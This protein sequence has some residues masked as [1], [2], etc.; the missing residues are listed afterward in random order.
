MA[1]SY[2]VRYTNE[3]P[4]LNDDAC[5]TT[6]LWLRRIPKGTFTMGS[7]EDE[8]GGCYDEK[9]H[10]VT[11]TQDYYIG[12]F[13]CTQKQWELVMGTKPSYFSNVNC[14]ETRP[15]EQVSYDDIRGTSWPSSGHTVDALSFMGRLKEKTGL[16]FD[17]PT[18]AQWEY[19][20]RAGLASALNSGKNLVLKEFDTRMNE[21]GRYWYNGGEEH[22]QDCTAVNGTA[23]VGCYLPNVWGLYDMHGNVVEWCLDWY[24]RDYDETDME[25]PTGSSGGFYRIVR[26]GSCGVYAWECRSASRGYCTS[27]DNS[28]D[29]G[30]RVVCLP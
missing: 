23:K 7:P 4:D 24:L 8:V 15:V 16:A 11:L 20:C 3:A 19:A 13:E 30:F 10:E 18:E 22:S 1:T 17:L 25:D 2:P 12:V 5:R 6:D 28:P 26:G 9:Q 14:Y 21:V 29:M 27:S